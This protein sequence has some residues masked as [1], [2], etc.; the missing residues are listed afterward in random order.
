[1]KGLAMG[2]LAVMAAVAAAQSGGYAA[3]EPGRLYAGTAKAD[4][5]PREEVAVNLSNRKLS[6]RERIDARV[7][8]LKNDE[9]SLAIVSLD[10]IL[11]SSAKVV[12]EAREKWGV[13]HV[14]LSST[15]THSSMAP[16][17]LRLT[18]RAGGGN[19]RDWTR[20]GNPGDIVDW[21]SLSE[22]P[23]YAATEEKIV[24]AIGEAMGNLFPAR[25]AA[26]TQPYENPYMASNRL[27]TT[28]DGKGHNRWGNYSRV[29]TEPRDPT[30]G[31]IRVDDEAGKA[32]ALLV[33]YACHP[34]LLM[35]ASFLSRDYP[36]VMVDTIEKELGP[37][38]MA[39][40]IQGAAGDQDPYDLHRY[41]GEKLLDTVRQSGVTLAR[42]AMRVRKTCLF[43][44]TSKHPLRIEETMVPI[45]Y[46]NGKGS[47]E[48]C[49]VTAIINDELALVTIP[50]EPHV[51]HQ[52][53][54]SAES[55][56]PNTFLLGYAYSGRGCPFLIYVPTEKAA[57]AGGYS[58]TECVFVEGAAGR[59]I[60]NTG[61]ACIENLLKNRE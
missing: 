22:D 59:K 37:D 36:G 19:R 60:V 58:A 29:P 14:I 34:V 7:L 4:I 21:P 16:E 10:L 53:D 33:H 38:C 17:G 55:P 47:T 2:I 23:W 27:F 18:P 26:K 13:E 44:K 28:S 51:Q 5:T 45:A 54:L 50:G 1:M 48:A 52:L 41:K 9:T 35:Y 12:A 11:F 24:A 39:M 3:E 40:F 20:A 49:I 42:E 57:K 43:H 46:R 32:R 56:A 31:V 25:I 15:H 30:I 6:I 61:L 8:V